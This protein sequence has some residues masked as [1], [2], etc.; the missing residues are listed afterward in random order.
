[1]LSSPTLA[2]GVDPIRDILRSGNVTRAKKLVTYLGR[3]R[4]GRY[5]FPCGCSRTNVFCPRIETRTEVPMIV[6]RRYYTR[7]RKTVVIRTKRNEL[8]L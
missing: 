5:P 3:T 1:M 6:F 2:V 7:R 4:I 8:R